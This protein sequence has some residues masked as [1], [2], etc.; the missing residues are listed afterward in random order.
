MEATKRADRMEK[1]SNNL[2]GR[3]GFGV[4]SVRGFFLSAAI[5]SPTLMEIPRLSIRSFN[6]VYPQKPFDFWA[7]CFYNWSVGE[8][9]LPEGGDNGMKRTL[10]VV[11]SMLVLT[12]FV[13]ALVGCGADIKAENE[14]LKAENTALKGSVDKMK[15][16]M[17]KLQDEVKKAGEKDAT[18]SSLTAENETLKKEVEE[19]KAKMAPKKKK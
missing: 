12:A 8:T 2:L 6:Y 9:T 14:K 13:A 17:Q 19:L 11:L 1:M 10:S 15:A 3:R 4:E 5:L 16:D 7:R 18:I